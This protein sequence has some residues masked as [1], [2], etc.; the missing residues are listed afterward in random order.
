MCLE[1]SNKNGIIGVFVLSILGAITFFGAPAF[2]SI[3]Y[4][5][6]NDD[7]WDYACQGTGK[8]SFLSGYGLL[9]HKKN[10]WPGSHTNAA[11]INEDI[12]RPCCGPRGNSMY[13]RC[14][15]PSYKQWG[16]ITEG[17]S[18]YT[19][20]SSSGTYTYLSATGYHFSCGNNMDWYATRMSITSNCANG[21]ISLNQDSLYEGRG[22]SGYFGWTTG[23]T[24][25]ILKADNSKI[26][27]AAS[28]G[29][30]NCKVTL[31]VCGGHTSSDCSEWHDHT[32]TY[33]FTVKQTTATCSK[34]YRLQNADGSYPSSYTPD[35][36]ETLGVG[37]TCSYEKSY[38]GYQT[39]KDSKTVTASG[40]TISLDLPRNTYTLTV[41]RDTSHIS[42]VTGG[43]TY[44]W[45]QTVNISA[46]AASNHAFSNWTRTNGDKGSFGNSNSA[47][48]TYTM[49]EG[50][51]TIQ[52]NGWANTFNLEYDGNSC[53]SSGLPSN[54]SATNTNESHQF[55]IDSTKPSVKTGYDFLGWA[56]TNNATSA[57]YNPG[58]KIKVD[59]NKTVT[60]YATCKM[61]ATFSGSIT[62]ANGSAALT[63]SGNERTGNGLHSQYKL[64]PTY[65]VKRENKYPD[66]EVVSRYAYNDSDKDDDSAYPTSH[67]GTMKGLTQNQTDSVT[68]AA[69]NIKVPISDNP[70]KHC[71]YLA[72]DDKVN[73][74]KDDEV[75]RSFTGK[76]KVCITINN[77][78]QTYSAHFTATSDAVVD[79][80]DKLIR[81]NSNRTGKIDN[82]TRITGTGTA[83]DGTYKDDYPSNDKYTATFTHKI[84]RTDSDASANAGT[85]YYV[86]SASSH[87]E[88][89]YCQDGGCEINNYNPYNPSLDNN[90]N[91]KVKSDDNDDTTIAA[92]ATATITTRPKWTLNASNKG[93][94][95]YMCQRIKYDEVTKYKTST[96]SS[97]S[98]SYKDTVTART[99]KYTTP[100]CITLKNPKWYTNISE[101]YLNH[102]I[103][104]QAEKPSAELVELDGLRPVGT[105][106]TTYEAFKV[107]ASGRWEHIL[108]R[109]D[110]KTVSG[111]NSSNFD[112]TDSGVNLFQPSIY[113]NND[114]AVTAKM[115]GSERL[116]GT[117]DTLKYINPIKS[118]NS[119][120]DFSVT[121]NAQGK[122]NGNTW[123]SNLGE[124]RTQTTVNANASPDEYTLLAGKS[125]KV[126]HS[127]YNSRA[128]WRVQYQQ[129]N[130]QETY[131]GWASGKSQKNSVYDR[132]VRI[133]QKPRECAL[134]DGV[135]RECE[136][137][138]DP[139]LPVARDSLDTFA[140]TK[141]TIIRPYNYKVT[142]VTPE[143]SSS[144]TSTYTGQS[145]EQ[146]FDLTVYKDS[147]AYEY[148]T[149]LENRKAFVVGY[150]IPS[151][152]TIGVAS[153]MVLGGRTASLDT[154]NPNAA[155]V[156]GFFRDRGAANCKILENGQNEI[157]P[158]DK[159]TNVYGGIDHYENAK[160]ITSSI[161][162]PQ[163][164][165]GAKYCVALAIAKYS[166]SST[167]WFISKSACNNVSKRPTVQVLGGDV[168]S[169]GYVSGSISKRGEK[170]Y[171]SWSDFTVS[172]S[173][174]ITGFAS[175]ASLANGATITGNN[176]V[177]PMCKIDALT[178]ANEQCKENP[179]ATELGGAVIPA[180]D[181]IRSVLDKMKSYYLTAGADSD[182]TCDSVRCWIN[183]VST[184]T[185][186]TFT[187][188]GLR[189]P[190]GFISSKPIILHS[191]GEM[192]I[193]TNITIEENHVYNDGLTPQIIILAEGN[194]MVKEH[195]TRIDAW[196]VAGG[197]FTSC[198]LDDG[199]ELNLSADVCTEPLTIKGAI[200]ANS[201]SFNRTY[202]GDPN[203]DNDD[204]LKN[205]AEKVYYSPVT[206]IQ[207][208]REAVRNAEPQIT[209]LN[210]L[211]PRK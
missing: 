170:Q 38:S 203:G 111:R 104:V 58:D 87:W 178:I 61:T 11:Y 196:I 71:F 69:K 86:A 118:S 74:V 124:G 206:L 180:T 26:R 45:G 115:W 156:C 106:G 175:S 186:N 73:F 78:P 123:T 167:D 192:I 102:Y 159:N 127:T 101:R 130:K 195:V 103:D 75:S 18:S 121:L 67:T 139:I 161:T 13:N 134:P 43:G 90:P 8:R 153:T 55:T 110:N 193:D 44:R 54:Q 150:V 149:D 165:T 33:S 200:T 166:S 30:L 128:A 109:Y 79:E 70:T 210:E 46:T 52:A 17:D 5:N 9:C 39:K 133:S 209:F 47:S 77:P 190:I 14:S 68:E 4:D 185:V 112:E 2:A 172:A 187:S 138:D 60:L 16:V 88:I 34:Q 184:V 21:A 194:I 35:G 169:N 114:F 25:N 105:D 208:A 131:T 7:G 27:S 211:A 157:T 12:V 64:T 92:G 63:G 31:H 174:T 42:A 99:E 176:S 122:N 94:Y 205:P 171:G 181:T 23:S 28:G 155:D 136:I 152:T 50:N 37:K 120:I 76:K 100:I 201:I 108:K 91:V 59:K 147:D 179:L 41:N 168:R 129:I 191:D 65:T 49:G 162:V 81:S 72:F 125:I 160:Y 95:V 62:V 80:H 29:T 183:G 84:K 154:N 93:K 97:N 173:K 198:T 135:D 177:Y 117:R 207:S 82:I 10:T 137:Q 158:H 146:T 116:P 96:N 197:T 51:V 22:T 140:P 163:V 164:E 85:T 142:D 132:T 19:I 199:S 107:E 188:K 182:G 151:K 40:V 141:Y 56:T 66:K 89:Q 24:T 48:T 204:S 148:I 144:D 57:S 83:A 113:S 119:S 202:G 1:F 36:S 15:S 126:S 6:Q 145:F 189:S 32:L 3:S 98:D 20:D 53:V 143:P